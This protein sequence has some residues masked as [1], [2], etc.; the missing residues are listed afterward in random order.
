MQSIF[1]FI[2]G[3]NL[4]STRK[5][6]LVPDEPSFTLLEIA[7]LIEAFYPGFTPALRHGLFR[8]V[9]TDVPS[10][11]PR[12]MHFMERSVSI[13]M[14]GSL[15]FRFS[16]RK[17]NATDAMADILGQM[18]GSAELLRFIKSLRGKY[19]TFAIDRVYITANIPSAAEQA[20]KE[21]LGDLIAT[22]A[23]LEGDFKHPDLVANAVVTY[24][25]V[26]PRAF[27]L[28][29]TFHGTH[30][31]FKDY[32]ERRA[33]N[34]PVF[35]IGTMNPPLTSLM[36]NICHPRM[37]AG[38]LLL[39]PLCGSGGILIEALVRGIFSIGLDIDWAAISGCLKNL[40]HFNNGMKA[41]FNILHASIF[42]L[43]FRETN[44]I[45]RS[46]LHV[47]TDPP[48]GRME[49]L[50]NVPLERYILKM[51]SLESDKL[52]FAIPENTAEEICAKIRENPSYEIKNV[53]VKREHPAFARA[54]VLIEKIC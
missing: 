14:L 17:D 38:T 23:R 51:I 53:Q 50:K 37:G 36:M 11:D 28:V 35:E 1:F 10:I 24:T 16:S 7:S 39:D 40:K 44:G 6:L 27:V 46:S 49:S 5:A 22:H 32:A 31:H 25:R 21:G 30:E 47:V 15:D 4:N 9:E 52:C 26:V 29:V 43:P 3:Q 13:R 8:V 2:T 54:I 18:A 12:F 33:R 41:G 34:R 20:V 42:A 45:T 19:A 48:Y